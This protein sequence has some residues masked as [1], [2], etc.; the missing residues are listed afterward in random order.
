MLFA[1][2]IYAGELL[3]LNTL[4]VGFFL[5]ILVTG[6]IF[7]CGQNYRY[8]GINPPSRNIINATDDQYFEPVNP[9]QTD[10]Y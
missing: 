9:N 2:F 4:I 1:G 3:S 5:S 8:R 10:S 7:G 6:L